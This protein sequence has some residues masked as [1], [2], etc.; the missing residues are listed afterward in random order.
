MIIIDLVYKF[1]VKF[2][3]VA[4]APPLLTA[5]PKTRPKAVNYTIPPSK[6]TSSGVTEKDRCQVIQRYRLLKSQGK[7]K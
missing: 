2:G 4:D 5:F 6:V 7:F 3:E 1:K